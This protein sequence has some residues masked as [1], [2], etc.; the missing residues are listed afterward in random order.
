MCTSCDFNDTLWLMI[1][2]ASMFSPTCP[3]LEFSSSPLSSTPSSSDFLPKNN[4]T[5]VR[6]STVFHNIATLCQVIYSMLFQL[7][8]TKILIQKPYLDLAED[9]NTTQSTQIHGTSMKRVPRHANRSTPG[10]HIVVPAHYWNSFTISH[11]KKKKAPKWRSCICTLYLCSFFL[12]ASCWSVLKPW[13]SHLDLLL[14][15]R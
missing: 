3:S 10:C 4:I 7:I 6:N 14:R 5:E 8:I 9:E 1:Q 11:K 2:T 12:T 13:E 15:P